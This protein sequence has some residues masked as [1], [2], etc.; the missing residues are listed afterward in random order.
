MVFNSIDRDANLLAK[1]HHSDWA[2]CNPQEVLVLMDI[3]SGSTPSMRLRWPRMLPFKCGS[4]PSPLQTVLKIGKSYR[5]LLT[6][7]STVSLVSHP[8]VHRLRLPMSLIRTKS[9][10]DAILVHSSRSTSPCLHAAS[11]LSW[12]RPAWIVQRSRLLASSE[13]YSAWGWKFAARFP[14]TFHF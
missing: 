9:S 13:V 14:I 10:P 5:R 2:T 1:T 7:R 8:R 4:N 3:S 11:S 6:C 12:S